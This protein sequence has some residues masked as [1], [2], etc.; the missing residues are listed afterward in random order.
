[1]P[2]KKICIQRSTCCTSDK[3]KL[4][5]QFCRSNDCCEKPSVVLLHNIGF[6]SNYWACTFKKFCP[7]ANVYALDFL[8]CGESEYVYHL[9]TRLTITKLIQ[10]LAE[11]LDCNHLSKVYLIGHGLGGIVALYFA[12]IYPHRV[13]KIAV[14]STSPKYYCDKTWQYEICS[15]VQK[16]TNKLWYEE[17]KCVTAKI[18]AT[19]TKLLDPNDCD[20]CKLTDQLIKSIGSQ[21]IY[22]Q[23]MNAVDARLILDHVKAPT[24]IMSGTHDPTVP[25]GATLYL[26]KHIPSS[27]IVEF[28]GYGTNFPILNSKLYNETVFNFF[29]VKC[30]PCRI[31]LVTEQE[32]NKCDNDC[33]GNKII[34][35][36]RYVK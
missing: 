11:F 29:F 15:H 26:R 35:Q 8:C 5:Y 17:D 32:T 21:I 1:M 24:L 3:L 27:A 13:I 18:A 10:D 36:C 30:D 7:V 28:F 31:S 19:I 20:R 33:D 14:S 12:A 23:T 6:D 9:S 2:K 22:S 16:L 4:S 25:I 34:I